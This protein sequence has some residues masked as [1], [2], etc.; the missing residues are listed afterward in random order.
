MLIKLVTHGITGVDILRRKR[1]CLYD[2]AWQFE[3]ICTWEHFE[4]ANVCE[5]RWEKKGKKGLFEETMYDPSSK[6]NSS[7]LFAPLETKIPLTGGVRK[8]FKSLSPRRFIDTNC[9]DERQPSRFAAC[10][11]SNRVRLASKHRRWIH[12]ETGVEETSARSRRAATP[13]A[14]L[15]LTFRSGLGLPRAICPWHYCDRELYT[16][17]VLADSRAHAT[18]NR[19]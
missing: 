15:T 14:R 9:V 2:K 8:R 1:P 7:P 17:P 16:F 10:T 11:V 12:Y 13:S 5:R 4:R 3:K 18:I 6:W 19:R